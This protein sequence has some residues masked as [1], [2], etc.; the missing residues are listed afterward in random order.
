MSSNL[1]GQL[2]EMILSGELKGGERITESSLAD[3]LGVSRT[4]IRSVLPTLEADGFIETV[5]KRGYAVKQF[6]AD[7]SLKALEL[8]AH[9][10]GLAAKYLAQSGASEE[11]L[12]Q[13]DQCL[14]QGDQIFA[15]RYLVKDDE[16]RYGLM[17]AKFHAV[18]VENCGS[19][20]LMAFIEKLNN[21]PFINPSVLIFDHV[22][23]EQ[24]YEL[25]F[26]AHGQ[27]HA[28]TDAIKRRDAARAEAVFREH[29]NAQIQSL[30]S[31]VVQNTH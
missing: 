4:P 18:I 9:L 13:L 3:K 23:L 12:M 21:M 28:L 15:K 5:G 24:A 25:L 29:G 6:N 11:T 26:R 22:G 14:A 30:F 19:A 20:P 2:R 1:L 7:E 27:H 17:N 31:R 10:E 8:R 16:E